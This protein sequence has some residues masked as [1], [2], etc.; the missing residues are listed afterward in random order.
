MSYHK[1]SPTGGV[2]ADS[3][4]PQLELLPRRGLE[5]IA[6]VLTFGAHKYDRDNWRKGLEWSRCIGAAQRHLLAY[7]NG[8]THDPETGLSHL[9]HAGCNILFVLEY[10]RT[11]PEL[12]DRPGQK[13]STLS[14]D[15]QD[16]IH[17]ME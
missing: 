16:F 14:E 6:K 2:K 10:E 17:G 4:K 8:E 1:A 15:L 11:H 9:A 5:E 7:A 13:V 3:S 12:D